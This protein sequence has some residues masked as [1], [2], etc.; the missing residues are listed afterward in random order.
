MILNIFA[1]VQIIFLIS[2]FL[3]FSIG[4]F[5]LFF[6]RLI[7][8]KALDTDLM[9]ILDIDL[10]LKN[11]FLAYLLTVLSL[12]MMVQISNINCLLFCIKSITAI[13]LKIA[14]GS[15]HSHNWWFFILLSCRKGFFSVEIQAWQVVC[16]LVVKLGVVRIK[17]GLTY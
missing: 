17:K 3:L 1:N 5:L 7:F 6:R 16:L 15:C 13:L 4:I 9:Q 11:H 10:I 2:A 12:E 14:F 8:I